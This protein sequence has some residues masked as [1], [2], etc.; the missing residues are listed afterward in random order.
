LLQVTGVSASFGPVQALAD[1]SFAVRAGE[2]V[3]LTG[4]P[5]AGKTTLARCIAGDIAPDAGG[6]LLRGRPVPADPAAAARHGISIL[7]QG[8]ALPDNLDVAGALLLGSET[9]WLMFSEPR[10]HSA[11]AALL[12]S[13]QIP[14]RDTTQLVRSLTSGQRQLIALA[15][16]LG[17]QPRLL[18]LDEPTAALGAAEAGEV[19]KLISRLRH[20]GTTV[21][22]V[23]G[24]SEQMFRMA[25]RIIVLRQGRIAGELDPRVTHPD[26]LAALQSG[27]EIGSSA[28]RQLTRLHGLADRSGSCSAR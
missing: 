7:W 25:D 15:A 18:I 14:I 28:R 21:L 6:I 2:L 13:L 4:E 12:A 8:L 9:R 23:S 27:Q 19:E 5:G 11:A 1:V 20:E 26:D 10:F 24:D 17:R 16:A 22:M 3:A